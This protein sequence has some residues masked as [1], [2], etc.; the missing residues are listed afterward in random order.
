MRNQDKRAAHE[1]SEPSTE[2]NHTAS[3]YQGRQ[4]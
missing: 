4:V 2:V 1:D 3:S